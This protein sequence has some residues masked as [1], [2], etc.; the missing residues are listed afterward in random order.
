MKLN[1]HSQVQYLQCTLYYHLYQLLVPRRQE[2][3]RTSNRRK[4]SCAGVLN[5]EHLS[6]PACAAMMMSSLVSI[7]DDIAFLQH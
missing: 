3:Q 5:P 7:C 4:I 6:L 2:P 1:G